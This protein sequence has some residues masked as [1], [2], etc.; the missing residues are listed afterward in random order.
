MKKC[1]DLDTIHSKITFDEWKNKIKVW[2]ESTLTSPSGFHLT[3]S[4]ALI[5]PHDIPPDHN[6][7]NA[8]ETQHQE[9]IEWQVHLLNTALT[10][11]Y[12][13]R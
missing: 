11:A 8:L 10:N 6:N 12:S 1:I 5:S 9:L 4:H 13:F 3:H 7:Y 2:K